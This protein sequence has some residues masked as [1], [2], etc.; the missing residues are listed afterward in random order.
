MKSNVIR[1]KTQA[2]ECEK[3]VAK[4]L[5][6]I[7]LVPKIKTYRPLKIEQEENNETPLKNEEN[8]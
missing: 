8:I 5:S 3:I 7:E 6:D 2:S 4:Q 1:M